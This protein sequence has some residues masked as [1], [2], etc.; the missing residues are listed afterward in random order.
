MCIR[1]SDRAEHERAEDAEEG[2]LDSV[3]GEG[4]RSRAAHGLTCSSSLTQRLDVTSAPVALLTKLVRQ[5]R[6]VDHQ[7]LW[8]SAVKSIS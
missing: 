4:T 7:I 6:T 1:D 8:N 2:R 5:T 3:E